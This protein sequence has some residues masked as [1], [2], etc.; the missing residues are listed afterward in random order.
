MSE[1]PTQ[2][3]GLIFFWQGH[4]CNSRTDTIRDFLSFGKEVKVFLKKLLN[5]CFM[6]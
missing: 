1:K 5:N 3:V 6:L 4:L 2:K